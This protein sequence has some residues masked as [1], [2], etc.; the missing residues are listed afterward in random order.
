MIARD[1]ILAE[2]QARAEAK[3]MTLDEWVKWYLASN[4]I[5]LDDCRA[6][7]TVAEALTE[8]DELPS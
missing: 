8:I 3:G 7:P 6:D 2:M 1:K 4:I 5:P